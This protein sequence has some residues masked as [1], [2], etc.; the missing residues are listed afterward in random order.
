MPEALDIKPSSLFRSWC[1]VLTAALFIF[2]IFIQMHL[3]NAIGSELISEFH[4]NTTQFGYLAAFYFY[5]NVL[6]L[7]PAGILLDRFSVRTLLLLAFTTT[8]IASYV[9][10]T[11]Y[12]FWVICLARLAI[13]VAGAF[14]FLSAVKLASRW[15]EPKHMALVVGVVI[16]IA[17]AGGVV[18]QTPMALLTQNLGWR[19]AMQIVTAFGVL[20]IIIQLIIVRDEPKCLE[21]VDTIEHTQLGK[22]SFWHSLGMAIKN[23]QNW[24]GGIYVSLVNLPIFVFSA[25][26]APYLVQVRH[27][28]P[29]Q[30]T[31]ATSMLFIGIMIGSPIAGIISDKMGLRKLPMIT[32]AALTFIA[33]LVITF[34]PEMPLWAVVCQFLFLGLAS[35]SQIIGYPVIAESNPYTITGTATSIASFLIMSGGLLIPVFGWLLNMHGSPVHSVADFTRANS[36]MLIGSAIALIAALIIKETYCKQFNQRN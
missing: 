20:L 4:F 36:M 22:T 23:T 29:V 5:G 1:V 10:S 35:S 27:L 24:L 11:T 31:M 18:A 30:A 15:F 6:F 3:F 34:A 2:Y 16:T 21:K 17:M 13:G 28:T 26:G 7:L 33:I 19:Y 25:F 14:A 32:G 9:F 8:I 12:V